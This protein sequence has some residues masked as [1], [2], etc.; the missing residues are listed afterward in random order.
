MF[1][2]KDEITLRKIAKI[3]DSSN[4]EQSKGSSTDTFFMASCYEPDFLKKI[5]KTVTSALVLEEKHPTAYQNAKKACSLFINLYKKDASF[6]NSLIEAWFNDPVIIKNFERNYNLEEILVGNLIYQQE[7]GTQGINKA[8]TK[9]EK[10]LVGNATHFHYLKNDVSRE[11]TQQKSTENA[12]RNNHGW[13]STIPKPK[14]TLDSFKDDVKEPCT[15][16]RNNGVLTISDMEFTGNVEINFEDSKLSVTLNDQSSTYYGKHVNFL[17]N[18]LL[19]DGKEAA[20]VT[21]QNQ[22]I[23]SELN[24][25]S[26]YQNLLIKA[27]VDV[28]Y[29]NA[30][31]ISGNHRHLGQWEKAIRMHYTKDNIWIAE[32]PLDAVGSE[33]KFLVGSYNAG[34]NPPVSALTWEN[35][36]NRE[37]S[38]TYYYLDLHSFPNKFNVYS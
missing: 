11:K 4:Q 22:S 9:N 17:G 19:I 30:L 10:V 7:S 25:P 20:R 34:M 23:R 26:L 1:T 5:L 27:V 3:F 29:G 6:K 33:F 36:T 38:S 12:S 18:K 2:E 8:P 37:V 24:Y 13:K 32:L 16:I 15:K 28:E 35:S 21:T 14:D 31:F